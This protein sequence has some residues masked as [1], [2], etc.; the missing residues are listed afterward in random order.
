MTDSAFTADTCRR[1]AARLLE[2]FQN[3]PKI[4]PAMRQAARDRGNSNIGCVLLLINQQTGN[5]EF[6]EPLG[7]ASSGTREART[8]SCY[9]R[10]MM[11]REKWTLQ[12]SRQ[13]PP[14]PGV[15]TIGVVRGRVHLYSVEGLGE[16][17]LDELFALLL[18]Y[19]MGEL[20][21]EQFVRLCATGGNPWTKQLEDKESL[22]VELDC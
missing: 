9:S 15:Q 10:A 16:S 3:H 8:R 14:V 20:M 4:G 6:A 19:K 1:A 18:A 12:L 7:K 11:F 5:H 21:R 17:D 22:V 13:C 2:R